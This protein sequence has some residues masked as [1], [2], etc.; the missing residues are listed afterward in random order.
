M[1]S[2]GRIDIHSTVLVTTLKT[3]GVVVCRLFLCI[4][5]H[6]MMAQAV[7]ASFGDVLAADIHTC[8]KSSRVTTTVLLARGM[9]AMS[10]KKKGAN[11]ERV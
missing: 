6:A 10:M 7:R 1:T 5:K 4:P 11:A 8:A 9:D 3:I 2:S